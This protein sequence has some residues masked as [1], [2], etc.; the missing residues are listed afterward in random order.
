MGMPRRGMDAMPYVSV[1]SVATDGSTRAPKS[2]MTET[3]THG[4]RAPLVV[5]LPAV[6]MASPEAW[7]VSPRNVMTGMPS[8]V[9]AAPLPVASSKEL[10]AAFSSLAVLVAGYPDDNVF[11]ANAD[12]NRKQDQTCHPSKEGAPQCNRVV[13]AGALK[14]GAGFLFHE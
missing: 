6:V 10:S 9:T 7:V 2:A 13:E 8:P 5:G 1:R 12:E 14:L 3:W 4:M 11:Q